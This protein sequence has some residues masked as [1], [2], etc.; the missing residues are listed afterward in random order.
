MKALLVLLATAGMALAEP[1]PV[2]RPDGDPLPVMQIAASLR[3]V[4]RA[5]VP[6]PVASRSPR[7]PDAVTFCGRPTLTGQ[8]IAPVEGPGACGIPDAVRITQVSGVSL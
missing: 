3:P 6:V 5:P 7:Q 8:S 1:R 2:P 4:P